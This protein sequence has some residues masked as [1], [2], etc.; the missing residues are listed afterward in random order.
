MAKPTKAQIDALVRAFGLYSH[1]Q[2]APLKVQQRLY[3]D[4][5][6]KLGKLIVMFPSI[7]LESDSFNNELKRRADEWWKSRAFTGPGVDW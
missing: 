5:R 2:S 1:S 7:D 6:K 4:Y 3:N